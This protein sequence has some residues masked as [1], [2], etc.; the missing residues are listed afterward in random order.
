MKTY[1]FTT[2]FGYSVSV[3]APDPDRARCAAKKAAGDKW[4]SSARIT[5]VTNAL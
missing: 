5:A 3:K 1:T 4:H 2:K